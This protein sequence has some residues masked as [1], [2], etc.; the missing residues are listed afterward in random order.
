MV[1]RKVAFGHGHFP[2]LQHNCQHVLEFSDYFP[3]ERT[4]KNFI[5]L[6]ILINFFYAVEAAASGPSAAWTRKGICSG[7]RILKLTR[8]SPDQLVTV[9]SPNSLRTNAFRRLVSGTGLGF[10]DF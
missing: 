9:I 5:A 10:A 1:I 2:T 3:S 8:A 6:T 4:A 7:E